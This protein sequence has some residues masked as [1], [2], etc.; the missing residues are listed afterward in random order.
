MDA[1]LIVLSRAPYR[2][3]RARAGLDTALAYAA[4]ECPL[5]V[6]FAG[7]G[8]LQLAPGQAP[9][10]IGRRSLRRIIESLPLY[11][12]EAVFADGAAVTRHGLAHEELPTFVRILDASG[13]RA[14][15]NGHRHVLSF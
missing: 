6:L 13:Q 12:L 14:L 11:D 4:F 2:S 15:Q 1:T 3:A 5:S 7:P 10:A 8:V 9:D